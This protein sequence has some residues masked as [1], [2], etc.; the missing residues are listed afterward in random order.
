MVKLFSNQGVDFAV[1]DVQSASKLQAL[2]HVPGTRSEAVVETRILMKRRSK[3]T[4]PFHVSI[5]IFGPGKGAEEVS[6]ALSRVKA[7]LQHPQDLNP[8]I[9]YRNPDYLTFPGVNINMKDCIG[10]GTSSWQ[11]D[12]LKRDIED[13][14][15]SLGQ[16][17]DNVDIGPIA[18]LKS[19]LKKCVWHTP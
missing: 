12:H 9:I 16:V 10:I 3:S 2:T 5:N 6:L 17:M 8:S 19:T 14:L 13:I 4:T 11:A 7:F 1:L 18:G 15:G